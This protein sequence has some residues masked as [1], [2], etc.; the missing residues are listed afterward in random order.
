MITI[1]ITKTTSYTQRVNLLT[2]E[3]PT[4]KKDRYDAVAM[5]KEYAIGDETLERTISLLE[6]NVE[7]D[8]NFD[9]AAVIVAI[10]KL[11]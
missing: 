4:D 8:A 11:G 3:T 10:N 2:K 5:E 7:D 6:Q 1:K 9:L